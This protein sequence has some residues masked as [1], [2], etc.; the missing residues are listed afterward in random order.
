VR[1]RIALRRGSVTLA[2]TTSR[3]DGTYVFRRTRATR[4]RSLRARVAELVR[5]ATVCAAAQS[6]LVKG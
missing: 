1:R 3:P 4:G 6:S 5:P 2:T